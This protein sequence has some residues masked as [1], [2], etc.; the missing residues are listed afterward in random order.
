MKRLVA[1]Q[2]AC[3]A[4]LLILVCDS[5]LGQTQTREQRS[6]RRDRVVPMKRIDLKSP[7]GGITFTLLP[8]AERL[9]FST[10]LGSSTVLDASP[11]VMKTDSYDLS[12]G[13]V[14]DTVETYEVN[15]TYP[16]YGAHSTTTNR[17]NG[18]KIWL[19]HDLSFIHYSLEVRVFD[20]GVAFRHVIPGSDS[21]TRTPD[22]YT[23]FV[24]PDGSVAWYHD[25]D[26]HYEAE[27]AKNGVA[28]VKHTSI[29][30]IADTLTRHLRARPS[31]AS[32]SSTCAGR[33]RPIYAGTI[34]SRMARSRNRAGWKSKA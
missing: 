29:H 3:A 28:D 19:K 6:R 25:L 33:L 21:L 23:T 9:T 15:E 34:R 4:L 7:N 12:S 2:A 13:V 30:T 17:C 14:L 20:D 11:I 5:L 22:E 32:C 27:Y 1:F 31:T 18:A 24:I 26:G 16:W 10:S 8:N